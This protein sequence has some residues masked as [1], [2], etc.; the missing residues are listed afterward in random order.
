[1]PFIVKEFK[2]N[3]GLDVSNPSYYTFD[4]YAELDGTSKWLS[5]PY[6]LFFPWII[7]ESKTLEKYID[8]HKFKN[9]EDVILDLNS[10][11]YNWNKNLAAYIEKF[12][13]KKL[14]D[15]LPTYCPETFDDLH[16]DEDDDD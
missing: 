8:N 2:D 4:I 16:N 14:F 6:E 10:L 1:M 11:D 7:R 5:V 9:W 15:I 3:V 13:H 12:Y